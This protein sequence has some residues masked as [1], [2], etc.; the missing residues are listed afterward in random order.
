MN[1]GENN[2]FLSYEIENHNFVM[3]VLKYFKLFCLDP[4]V[5][6]SNLCLDT[7]LYRISY[8]FII[9]YLHFSTNDR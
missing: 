6:T 4:Q 3:F 9:V 1:R 7:F 2:W 8:I 5:G